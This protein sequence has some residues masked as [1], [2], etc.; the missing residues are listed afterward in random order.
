MRTSV[1]YACADDE[2]VFQKRMLRRSE[3][4]INRDAATLLVTYL[5]SPA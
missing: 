1:S 4:S 2:R 5:S 3:A